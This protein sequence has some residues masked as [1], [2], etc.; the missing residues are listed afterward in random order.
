LKP[1]L[2]ELGKSRAWATETKQLLLDPGGPFP[3]GERIGDTWPGARSA[4]PGLY[5]ES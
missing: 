5:L 1:I 2:A 4:R 3:R